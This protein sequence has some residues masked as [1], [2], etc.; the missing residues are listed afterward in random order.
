[1]DGLFGFI[2]GAVCTFLALAALLISP[3][4]GEVTRNLAERA[5]VEWCGPEEKVRSYADLTCTCD[6]G[7]H[8]YMDTSKMFTEF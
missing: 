2:L 5:C 8:G 7:R 3:M 6:S 1:M 4:P